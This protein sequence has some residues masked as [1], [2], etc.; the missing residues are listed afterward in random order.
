MDRPMGG[1]IKFPRNGAL[2]GDAKWND[3]ESASM[4]SR[5]DREASLISWID[6]TQQRDGDDDRDGGGGAAA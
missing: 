2:R 4:T 1:L 5:A 3:R 6:V